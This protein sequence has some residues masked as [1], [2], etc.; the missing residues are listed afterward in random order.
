MPHTAASTAR[1]YTVRSASSVELND[2][3]VLEPVC[4]FIVVAPLFRL[5]PRCLRRKGYFDHSTLIRWKESRRADV[6]RRGRVHRRAS[7]RKAGDCRH[8]QNGKFFRIIANL[9]IVTATRDRVGIEIEMNDLSETLNGGQVY[10][11]APPRRP[12]FTPGF[13]GFGPSQVEKNAF[14][15]SS[16]LIVPF[17]V[18]LTST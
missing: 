4:A 8:Q 6:L 5:A 1:R 7:G 2:D 12:A 16:P 14:A 13:G 15:K 10:S 17:T 18:P 3:S 11:Q 9:S